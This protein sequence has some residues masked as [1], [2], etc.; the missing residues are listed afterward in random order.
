MLAPFL[1]GKDRTGLSPPCSP[2]YTR[3]KIRDGTSRSGGEGEMGGHGG[4]KYSK[5]DANITAKPV[6]VH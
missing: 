2:G 1:V 6:F 4:W 5:Y 3:N